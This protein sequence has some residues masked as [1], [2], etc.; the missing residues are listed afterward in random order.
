MGVKRIRARVVK[1]SDGQ[2]YTRMTARELFE[3]WKAADGRGEIDL[4]TWAAI[5]AYLS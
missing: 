4:Q 2:P 3:A 5:R 1:E